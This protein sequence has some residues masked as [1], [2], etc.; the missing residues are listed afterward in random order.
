MLGFSYAAAWLMTGVG[1]KVGLAERR[2]W[3]AATA[4]SVCVLLGAPLPLRYSTQVLSP[5]AALLLWLVLVHTL[6]GREHVRR[7][8]LFWGGLTAAYAAA[9]CLSV[10]T[11]A[12]TVLAA[13]ALR[14]LSLDD[15]L[16]IE[17][18]GEDPRD[19]VVMATTYE[20]A[21]V[22]EALAR[23]VPYTPSR[24]DFEDG[25]RVTIRTRRGPTAFDIYRGRR[26]RLDTAVLALTPAGGFV[27][28][29]AYYENQTLYWLLVTNYRFPV[30]FP[31]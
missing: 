24:E 16:G 3:Q 26:G 19:R 1:R 22:L 8:G 14:Y 15:V 12:R 2:T 7:P 17:F 21:D 13:D 4:L 5:F 30:W 28:G 9:V 25:Y 20:L 23:T 18:R 6:A 10:C 11:S 31:E 29:P 27:L